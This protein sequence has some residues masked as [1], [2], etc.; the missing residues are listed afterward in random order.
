MKIV[1]PK[2]S[3]TL[4]LKPFSTIYSEEEPMLEMCKVVNDE[5]IEAFFDRPRFYN[6]EFDHCQFTNSDFSQVEFVD[7]RFTNC[8]LSNVNMTKA[9]IHRVEFI[10]CKLLGTTF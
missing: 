2:I 10:N 9:S 3:P 1:P 5:A 7:V 6:M 4:P 8:D